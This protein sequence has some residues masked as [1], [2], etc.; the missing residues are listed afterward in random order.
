MQTV[1]TAQSLPEAIAEHY[2]YMRRVAYRMTRDMDR[3]D[4]YVQASYV[5]CIERIDKCNLSRDGATFKQFCAQTTVFTVR[6]IRKSEQRLAKRLCD[7]AVL[8]SVFASLPDRDQCKAIRAA[9]RKLS[10]AYRKTLR[11]YFNGTLSKDGAARFRLHDARK[12]LGKL[13]AQ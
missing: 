5:A 11:A 10:P 9:W 4:D 13:L 8:G 6:T 12:T 3:L 1:Y 2:D 7:N